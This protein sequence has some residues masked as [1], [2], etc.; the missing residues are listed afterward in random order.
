MDS[1]KPSGDSGWHIMFEIDSVGGKYAL[2]PI[3]PGVFI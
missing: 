1:T 2:E 3:G